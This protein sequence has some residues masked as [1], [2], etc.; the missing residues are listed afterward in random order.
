MIITISGD[1]G[2]G[3]STVGKLLMK[4]LGYQYLSTGSIQRKIAEEMGMTTLELNIL[5]ETD[6]SIDKKIDG[7]TSALSD[8]NED[9]I[10]DS[11]L[12]WHFIPDSYKVFLSCEQEIAASRIFHDHNR[13]SDEDK[14]SI[15]LLL[16]KI[17]DRRKSEKRRFLKKY[18]VDFEDYSN[19]DMIIDTGYFSPEQVAELIL[20]GVR[21][22][23]QDIEQPDS[24]SPSGSADESQ[25]TV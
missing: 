2:S 6:H 11:R 13:I 16:Q 23:H 3:K 22:Y 21:F 8:N 17:I 20:D 19:Y 9:Y 7:Y 12:A 5:S 15:D 18:G 4:K 25:Q 24:V 14:S 10:V 1:I